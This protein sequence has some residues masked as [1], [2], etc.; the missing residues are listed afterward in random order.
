MDVHYEHFSKMVLYLCLILVN[1]MGDGFATKIKT[2]LGTIIS[3]SLL[4]GK[5][6]YLFTYRL[7][8]RLM[9]LALNLHLFRSWAVRL[10]FLIAFLASLFRKISFQWIMSHDL[11]KLWT[12]YQG[13]RCPTGHGSVYTPCYFTMFMKIIIVQ[14]NIYG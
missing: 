4:L 14:S 8:C 10:T 6:I 13:S 7:L 9:L 3:L 2:K 5:C 1:A 12:V 11:T